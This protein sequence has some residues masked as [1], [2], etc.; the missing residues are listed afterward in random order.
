M[1]QFRETIDNHREQN[2]AD[3]TGPAEKEHGLIAECIDCGD[4][5]GSLR[6]R[7]FARFVFAANAIPAPVGARFHQEAFAGL[8]NGGNFD[9]LS[10]SSRIGQF[11]STAIRRSLNVGL[12][13]TGWPTA[14]SI[15]SS[16]ELSEKA[17]DSSRS[18]PSCA[19]YS[20]MARAFSFW[21]S[22]GGSTRPEAIWF[23]NSRRLQMTS[24]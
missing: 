13:A 4:L 16:A 5:A 2:L 10:P 12:V 1:F 9:E 20:R 11:L 14:E 21:A 15:G 7:R 6:R 17:Q 23:L 8:R 3:K 18:M 22:S 24:S 19:A